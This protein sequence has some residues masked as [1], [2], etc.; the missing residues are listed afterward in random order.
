VIEA[1][2]TSGVKYQVGFNRRFDRNFK[3]VHE[4]VK[5]GG[6]GDVHIVKVTSRDP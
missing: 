5:Q 3:R 2:K 1:V 6:V 4:V